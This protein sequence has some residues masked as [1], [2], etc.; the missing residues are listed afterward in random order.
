MIE[1]FVQNLLKKKDQSYKFNKKENFPCIKLILDSINDKYIDKTTIYNYL[2]N[3]NLSR[4]PEIDI[5]NI[6]PKEIYILEKNEDFNVG[7]ILLFKTKKNRF[8]FAVIVKK[9][10]KNIEIIHV[11]NRKL[12][13]IQSILD[14]HL[15][16][17]LI[18]ILR[19]SN[20]NTS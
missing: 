20:A 15:K 4:N 7:D 11:E 5:K 2:L 17:N 16:K 1:E 10:E 14:D 3:L 18:N 6:L 12:T 19:F 9:F 8:H 13:I